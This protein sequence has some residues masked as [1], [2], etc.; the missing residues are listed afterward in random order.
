MNITSK[1]LRRPLALVVLVIAI[2]VVGWFS[3][4]Q[5]EV[6]YL[7]KVTYPM[8]RMHIYWRGATPEE[9]EKNI[10]EPIEVA[11]ATVDKLDYLES[12]SIEGMYT[13]LVNFHYGV[14]V[15]EAYQDVTAVMGRVARRLPS[16]IDPPIIIK[17]DPSQLPIME[18]TVSSDQRDLVELRDW[19]E[20]WLAERLTAVHGT[21]GV[22]VV[23]G[24]K[25]EIRVY[26]DPQRLRAYNLSPARISRALFEENQQMFAG[27]VTVESREIIARTMGEFTGIDEIRNIVVTRGPNGEN[28]YLRD[29]ASVEDSHEEMRVNTRFNGK[30]CVKL[31]VLK[32]AEANT[33]QV[34]RDVQARIEQLRADIPEDIQFGFVENQGD[35]VMGAINSVKNSAIIAALLVILIV[36]LFLGKWRQVL[37]MMIALPFT[38]LANFF[39][40]RTA[41]FSIN[42]FSLGGLVV[43]LGVILDNSIVVLEN[44]TRLK[45]ENEEEYSLKGT[46]EVSS[47]IIAATLTFLVIFLPFLF[48][49][50]LVALL[51]KELILVIAGIVIVSLV[52]AVTLTPLLT[53]V[54]IRKEKPG[55][56]SG[57]TRGI[58]TV[59]TSFTRGYSVLLKMCLNLRYF[60]I[61]L[62]LAAFVISLMLANAVGSEFLPR[63]DDGRIMIRVMMPSGTAVSEVDNILR[64][65]EDE[66]IGMPGIESV[67]TLAGGKVWGLYTYE[68]ASEGEVNIQLVPKSQ[69]NISTQEFV[70]KLR[71]IIGQIKHPGARIPV[72][73]M[74]V[75]GIRRMG[76]QEIEVK[77]KG[78]DINTIFEFAGEVSDRLSKTP[79]LTNINTSLDMTKPE[80]R[81][82]IDRARA[83]AMNISVNQIATTMRSLVSGTV[84]THYL[85][86]GEYYNIR[87]IVP[88]QKLTSMSDVE[89]L[90]LDTGRGKPVYLHEVAEV[91]RAVG[92]VEIV[93][94]DQLKMVVVRADASGVSIGEAVSSAQQ[95]VSQTGLPSGV[96]FEMGGQAQAMAENNKVLLTIIG[97]SVLFAFVILTIQFNS[98][99]LPILIILNIPLALTGTFL[100]LFLTGRPIGMTVMIG[101]VVMMGGITSQGV[102]LLSLAEELRQKGE[103]VSEAIMK[104]S[105]TRVRPILM[106]QLTTVLGLVPLALNIGEGGDM[107]VPMAI[108]VIGGLLYSLV[109]TLFF[110]PVSYKILYSHKKLAVLVDFARTIVD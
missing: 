106:T 73:Q 16:D 37:V 33:V 31:S 88:E 93:R 61:L 107:L 66:I 85:D 19:S 83:S 24:L 8:V 110:L 21:A 74:Q 52:V 96:E 60:V 9:I 43:S 72:M 17:A 14:R 62:V 13:L 102:V 109:L 38:L 35:Y 39:I 65:I 25:R 98:I 95:A 26:L 57:L 79:G 47:A 75:K 64:R 81:I 4:L 1:V 97:F 51:F 70:N 78:S 91:S 53:H 30:P 12:S 80:Y 108:A 84:A 50:G 5:L 46:N 3:F 87:V 82:Y 76:D 10:A 89:N 63:L 28:V 55:K 86:G 18:V 90:V 68:I 49:P 69:R 2:A 41:G 15:E 6:D 29:I 27:R 11:M 58:D 71:P 7:P 103:S 59:I 105:T 92:P 100:A 36:Y 22:E 56:S 44:I 94:E 20:N 34:S 45:S 104:A 42:I 67:F 77:I 48:V 54:L 32:Q 40:M 99:A 23:G 101:I